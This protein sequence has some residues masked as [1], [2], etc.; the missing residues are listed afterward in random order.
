[1][2]KKKSVFFFKIIQTYTII[3][4][5]ETWSIYTLDICE[6]FTNGELFFANFT[7][8]IS[9]TVL[10]SVERICRFCNDRH[11]GQS[12]TPNFR[13]SMHESHPFWMSWPPLDKGNLLQPSWPQLGK[14]KT[15]GQGCDFNG[16]C[17]EILCTSSCVFVMRH[18][19]LT[20]GILQAHSAV[21]MRCNGLKQ[22]D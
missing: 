2:C 11:L 20:K 12:V 18:I 7:E 14:V 3:C 9:V 15:A 13:S 1:M 4:P 22:V 19:L 16:S 8:C 17:T 6:L 21:V 5:I 10:L